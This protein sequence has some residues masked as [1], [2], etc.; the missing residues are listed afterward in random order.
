MRCCRGV[1]KPKSEFF[2]LK[3]EI[4]EL[5][6]YVSLTPVKTGNSLNR[7]IH[8]PANIFYN[9]GMVYDTSF[10]SFIEYRCFL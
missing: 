10:S 1:K 4:E 7:N 5:K 9:S 6:S 8:I 2:K 3:H